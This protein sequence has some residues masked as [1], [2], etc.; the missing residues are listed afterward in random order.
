MSSLISHKEGD[1]ISRAM[2]IVSYAESGL[3]SCV[4]LSLGSS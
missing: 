4:M 2:E 1:G 3:P